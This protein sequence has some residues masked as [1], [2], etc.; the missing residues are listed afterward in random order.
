MQS[1]A[2]FGNGLRVIGRKSY[3]VEG[4]R[5]LDF[6]DRG[7]VFRKPDQ[8]ELS[9]II[10]DGV[11]ILC[12]IQSLMSKSDRHAYWREQE[13]YEQP[14]GRQADRR[15]VVLPKA[16]PQAHLTPQQLGA[17]VYCFADG[18]D[19]GDSETPPALRN[20]CGECSRD[21]FQAAASAGKHLP[22]GRK[23]QS[24]SRCCELIR[25]L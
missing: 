17:K 24:C 9:V 1:Q 2:S 21:G 5:F 25:P 12:E 6:D 14:H 4:E 15:I 13:F 23:Q 16:D 19:L 20:T 7:V 18:V 3:K 11:L 8:V 10:Y 22:T